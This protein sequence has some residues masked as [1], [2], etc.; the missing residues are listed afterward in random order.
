MAMDLT[1]LST[2]DTPLTYSRQLAGKREKEKK[3]RV[4]ALGLRKAEE[5]EPLL[6]IGGS[7]HHYLSH[8]LIVIDI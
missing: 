3:N 6:V 5:K 4:S 7:N 1:N 2:P 8:I